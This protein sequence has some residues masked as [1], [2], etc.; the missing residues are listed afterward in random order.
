MPQDIKWRTSTLIRPGLCRIIR[1]AT[2]IIRMPGDDRQG[3][4]QL[5][6]RHSRGIQLV[7]SDQYR[8]LQ[9]FRCGCVL[10]QPEAYFMLDR[11][12]HGLQAALAGQL[13]FG[14]QLKTYHRP[15]RFI[16]QKVQTEPDAALLPMQ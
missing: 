16:V 4:D 6:F 7:V 9:T 15:A 11:P 14:M 10:G 12:V 3:Q 13:Q 5:V 8:I 1:Q 2:G